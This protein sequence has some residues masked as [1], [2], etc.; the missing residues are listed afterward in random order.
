MQDNY[1]KKKLSN[2]KNYTNAD[3]S[4]YRDNTLNEHPATSSFKKHCKNA[5]KD[6]APSGLV[7]L[8]GLL[9]LDSNTYRR[10]LIWFTFKKIFKFTIKH[11]VMC[12]ILRRG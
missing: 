9:W 8:D 5:F 4:L 11:G 3:L 1:L 2:Y 10:N 12:R 6:V 7:G